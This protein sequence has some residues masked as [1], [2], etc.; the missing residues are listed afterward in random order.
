MPKEMELRVKRGYTF[1]EGGST[2]ETIQLQQYID[3][4]WRNVP[5]DWYQD[6]EL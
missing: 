4:E 6:G 2:V 1:P 5:E 3:G